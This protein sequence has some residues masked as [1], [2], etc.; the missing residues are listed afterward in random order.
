MRR[1]GLVLMVV[2]LVAPGCGLLM[3]DTPAGPPESRVVVGSHGP[4]VPPPLPRQRPRPVVDISGKWSGSWRG[5]DVMGVVRNE[6]ATADLRQQGSRGTG[7]FVLHTTGVAA[8]VPIEVRNAGLTGVPVQFEVSGS[9]VVIRHELGSRLFA[10]DLEVEGDRMLGRVRGAEPEVRI[11]LTRVRP[12][13]AAAPRGSVATAPPGSGAAAPPGSGAPEPP[14]PPSSPPGPTLEPADS[15]PSTTER[16][17][18]AAP[19]SPPE[20]T[21][22]EPARPGPNE[23]TGSAAVKPIYFDFDKYDI[24]PGDAKIL[25]ANAEWLKKSAAMLVLLEGHCDERGTIEYNLALGERRARAARNYLI[26]SGVAA[27]RISIV[28]F[29]AERPVC[30]EATEECWSKNRRAVFLLRPR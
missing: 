29:G 8:G 11:V 21:P 12:P 25:A 2:A 9:R 28:S 13:V 4:S 30:T 20:P 7:R 19:A 6:D 10:A 1:V 26:S 24:R 3:A 23:F 22:A 17:I 14:P 16:P 18:A 5:Y 15:E 27:E